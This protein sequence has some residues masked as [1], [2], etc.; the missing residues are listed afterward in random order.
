MNKIR[1]TPVGLESPT[2]SSEEFSA[3]EDNVRA[4]TS[5]ADKDMLEFFHSSKNIIDT[6]SEENEMN[7]TD[8][9]F[10]RHQK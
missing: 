3:V 10:P 7:N 6:D 8:L 5:M 4:A 2:V 9:V 1:K